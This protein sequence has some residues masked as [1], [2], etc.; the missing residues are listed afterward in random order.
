MTAEGPRAAEGVWLITG[1][2]KGIGRA[3][4]EEALARGARVAAI[5]RRDGDLDLSERYRGR[6]LHLK[7]DVAA[8]DERACDRMATTVAEHFGRIDVLVNNAGHG[9]ITNFEETSEAG[10]RELFEL[11]F[12]GL[13]R[14]TRAVLPFMR[15][16]REGHIVNIASAAGYGAG[17][18]IY[19]SSKFAV[20]GFSTC[21]AFELEP[22][23]ISVTN[24]APGLF[25]TN[26]YDAGA[27]CIEPDT[28]IADYDAF[29]WQEDFMRESGTGQPGDPQ[30]LARLVC[31]V[32]ESDAP[33][34]HLPVGLDAVETVEAQIAKMQADVDAWRY[35]TTRTDFRD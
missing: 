22:F 18:A 13:M 14:V 27:L 6:F 11:N 3:L 15:H 32:V 2:A 4:T 31:D 8:A 26:F 34:L 21:L 1:A 33:P 23:G 5:T 19:H 12:F 30:Q 20:T 29:R 9:R 10:I 17:P 7:H 24:V 16:Q 35:R 25:R 28:P